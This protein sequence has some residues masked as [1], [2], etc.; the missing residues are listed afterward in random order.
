LVS[1]Q[2]RVRLA[3]GLL[4]LLLLT[5]T[6]PLLFGF[7]LEFFGD[8]SVDEVSLESLL[9]H[10]L[11]IVHLELMELLANSLGVLLLAVELSYQLSFDLLVISLHLRMIQ[12]LPLFLKSPLMI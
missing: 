12:L 7:T 5:A 2:V 8:L 4:L 1:K 10:A 3:E 11:D 9:L 6:L